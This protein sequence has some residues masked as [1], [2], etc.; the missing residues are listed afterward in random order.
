MRPGTVNSPV[1][2]GVVPARIFRRVLLPEPFSPMRPITSPRS[3]AARD[4]PEGVHRRVCC[5]GR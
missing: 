5:G 3:S 4:A 1:V 2:G